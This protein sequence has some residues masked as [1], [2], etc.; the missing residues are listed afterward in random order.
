MGITLQAGQFVTTGTCM[1]PLELI[2]GDEVLADYGEL[3]QMGMR[4]E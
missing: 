2:E 1:Q 4:F 3:G